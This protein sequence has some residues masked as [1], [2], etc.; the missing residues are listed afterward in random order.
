VTGWSNDYGRQFD[1][2]SSD[3][4]V[5]LASW[6]SEQCVKKQCG[7]ALD[8]RRV[9]RVVPMM[10]Q[11]RNYQFNIKQKGVMHLNTLAMLSIQHDFCHVQ[12]NWKL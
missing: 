11:D 12:N 4:L 9:R 3:T 8:L 5:W 2:V 7:L 1:S 6:L 10:K